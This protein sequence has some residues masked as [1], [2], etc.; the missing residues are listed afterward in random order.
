MSE[1]TVTPRGLSRLGPGILVAAT[2][3]G[4]GDL[5]AAAVAGRQFGLALLWVVLVGA[6]CKWLLNEGIARWQLATGESVIAAWATRLPRWVYWY[7]GAYLIVWGFLV[8]AA[9]GSACGVAMKALWPDAPGSVALWAVVHA[10]AGWAIVKGGRY[11][12]FEKMMQILIGLMFIFVIGCGVALVQNWSGVMAGLLVPVI[13]EGGLWISLGLM[14]GVG[15]SATLLCYGY[16]LKE[17][18]WQ[19]ATFHPL[20]RWDLLLAYGLTAAFAVA[21]IIIAAGAEPQDS[22]GTALVVALADELGS[23]LGPM[24]K[25]MFLS[26]FWCAVFTSL[27]GV[28]QGVPYLF[29]DWWKRRRKGQSGP[30]EPG[31][32]RSYGAFLAYLAL[33]PLMLQVMDRPLL[34]VVVYAIAGAFFMP[35]LAGTLLVINNRREWVGELKNSGWVNAGLIV[36]LALFGALLGLEIKNR[37]FG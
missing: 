36:S 30:A 29:E 8:G 18:G 9:L 35:L 28:W 20:A 31:R 13:P 1:A 12:V 17:K 25:T 33:F 24:G 21:M 26:G 10:V 3:V 15:G 5:I 32:T 7:F 16:W 22:S 6:G 11:R 23:K 2:G 14:G 27:L 19:G 4:A 37:L 34:I